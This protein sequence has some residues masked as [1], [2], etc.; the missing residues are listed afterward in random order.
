MGPWKHIELERHEAV[1]GLWLNR[2]ELRNAFNADLIGEL[3]ACLAGLAQEEGLRALVLGGR[4]DVF[5]AGADLDYMRTV[6]DIGEAANYRDAMELAEM[7]A[8]LDAFPCPVVARVQGAAM[9]GGVGLVACCDI[10]VCTSDVR[11]GFSE[12]RLGLSPATI[13]PYVVGK[14]GATHARHLFL[15]GERFDAEQA[16]AYGLVHRIV[17]PEQ[18]DSAVEAVVADL[19]S[20]GPQAARATKR[21]LRTL[22]GI[23]DAATQAM[24]ARLIAELRASQEGQEGIAAFLDRRAPSWKPPQG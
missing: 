2:A 1:A 8:A 14:I 9:G 18:L 10:A 19:M 11:L 15:T 24:T 23:R 3:S 13:A 21:L 16:L 12:V 17:E 6:A 7:L 4:G 5:C 22:G 20:G